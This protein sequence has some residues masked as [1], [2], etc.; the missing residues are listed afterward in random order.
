MGAISPCEEV[1][2]FQSGPCVAA[3]QATSLIASWVAAEAARAFWTVPER[4]KPIGMLV[5]TG[6]GGVTGAGWM[7]FGVEAASMA[8]ELAARMAKTSEPD[9]SMA[10]ATAS[11]CGHGVR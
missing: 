2:D 5:E 8:S 7:A 11:E 1:D 4:V 10:V 6:K 3:E 9:A